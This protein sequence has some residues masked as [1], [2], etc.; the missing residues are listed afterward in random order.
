MA[1]RE[2]YKPKRTYLP[3]NLPVHQPEKIQPA[4]FAKPIIAM[5]VEATVAGRPQS[6]IS[7]GRWVT[8]KAMWKPQ[9][10][11]PKCSKI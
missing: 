3:K 8:K 6:E 5:E 9:V 2:A 1:T 11:K 7:V 10:K 4:M